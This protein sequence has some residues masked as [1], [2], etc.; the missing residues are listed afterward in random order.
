MRRGYDFRALAIDGTEIISQEDPDGDFSSSDG[1][2]DKSPGYLSQQLDER[3]RDFVNGI[4][5]LP[6]TKYVQMNQ[7][8]KDPL[9]NTDAR[10]PFENDVTS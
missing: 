2:M 4:E 8:I 1:K 9:Q 6:R 7:D 5:P 3:M 10:P